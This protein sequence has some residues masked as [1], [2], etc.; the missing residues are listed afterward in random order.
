[1]VQ[2]SGCRVVGCPR[3]EGGSRTVLAHRDGQRGSASVGIVALKR[4]VGVQMDGLAALD[5]SRIKAR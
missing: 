1:M 2:G 4:A 5:V 3:L